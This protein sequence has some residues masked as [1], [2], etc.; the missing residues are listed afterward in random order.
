M[1]CLC[2]TSR[3]GEPEEAERRSRNTEGEDR[4]EREDEILISVAFSETCDVM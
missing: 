2:G 1:R 4:G 3:A